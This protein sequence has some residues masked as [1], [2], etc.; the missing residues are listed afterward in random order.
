MSTV[1][2]SPAATSSSDGA[3]RVNAASR[4]MKRALL[5]DAGMTAFYEP[6]IDGF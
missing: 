4:P 3:N 1:V 2:A 6:P 5:I